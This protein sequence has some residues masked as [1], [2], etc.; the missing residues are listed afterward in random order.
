VRSV[1]YPS[2]KDGDSG[3]SASK[4]ATTGLA[5]AAVV[6]GCWPGRAATGIA[7]VSVIRCAV[8]LGAVA[9][10]GALAPLGVEKL[11]G[12]AGMLGADGPVARVVSALGETEAGPRDMEASVGEAG[13]DTVRETGSGRG[14]E[15]AG[16]TARAGTVAGAGS[17]VVRDTVSGVS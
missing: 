13:S 17:R 5:S 3:R 8:S 9:P 16:G 15:D 7:T 10:L 12:V 1:V 14:G 2:S 6:S 11:V 4:R